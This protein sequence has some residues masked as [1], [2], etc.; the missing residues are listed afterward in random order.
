VDAIG[1]RR[2]TSRPDFG[3]DVADYLDVDPRFGSLADF[4][5]LI[6]EASAGSA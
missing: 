1:S 5:Q 2:S 6:A 4:D 3:Y